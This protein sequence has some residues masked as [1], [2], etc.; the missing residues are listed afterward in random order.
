MIRCNKCGERSCGCSP[1]K[2]P[3]K[4]RSN[5]TIVINTNEIPNA[6]EVEFDNSETGLSSSNIQEAIEELDSNIEE[7]LSNSVKTIG[8]TLVTNIQDEED[9]SIL[10]TN[11]NGRI[12]QEGDRI[13]GGLRLGRS[14]DVGTQLWQESKVTIAANVFDGVINEENGSSITVQNSNI[15]QAIKT[16]G[17]TSNIVNS[18]PAK[19]THEIVLPSDLGSNKASLGTDGFHVELST[20]DYDTQ[21]HIDENI[22]VNKLPRVADDIEPTEDNELVTKSYVDN[23]P[24]DGSNLS[25]LPWAKAESSVLSYNGTVL[26]RSP[27]SE[28]VVSDA[29][30]VRTTRGELLAMAP[31]ISELETTPNSNTLVPWRRLKERL[32]GF[33]SNI[34]YDSDEHILTFERYDETPITVDLPIESLI[35]N[36]DLDDDDTL[37]LTFEDGS[38]REIPLSTLLVGVVKSVNNETPNSAG[39]VQLGINNIPDLVEALEGKVEKAEVTIDI[40]DVPSGTTVNTTVEGLILTSTGEPITLSFPQ[41]NIP[42][43]IEVEGAFVIGGKAIIETTQSGTTQ[44]L[45]VEVT[46]ELNSVGGLSSDNIGNNLTIDDLGKLNVGVPYVLEL[47][48]ALAGSGATIGD[49]KLMVVNTGPL[50]NE[51]IT[52][53]FD[54]EALDGI[55]LTASY[56]C[57]VLGGFID[58]QVG[59][60]TQRVNI[61]FTSLPVP[62]IPSSIILDNFSKII[63]LQTSRMAKIYT[64]GDQRQSITVGNFDNEDNPINRIQLTQF[65][66]PRIELLTNN[67]SIEFSADG[68]RKALHISPTGGFFTNSQSLYIEGIS[69]TTNTNEHTD[70]TVQSL[71]NIAIRQVANPS[72]FSSILHEGGNEYSITAVNN[73]DE[74]KGLQMIKDEDTEEITTRLTGDDIKLES[75]GIDLDL[76]TVGEISGRTLYSALLYDKEGF[77]EIGIT[78]LNGEENENSNL[79]SISLTVATDEGHNSSSNY[80]NY[81]INL[82]NKTDA[83]LD[84]NEGIHIGNVNLIPSLKKGFF[85]TEIG[86]LT[87]NLQLKAEEIEFSTYPNILEG[88]IL[89]DDN[90]LVP[91][92]YVD[93]QIEDMQTIINDLTQRLEA[94]ENA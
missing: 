57:V 27:V 47:D 72:S 90:Q 84:V 48:P 65:P 32:N 30:P 5:R 86:A 82:N 35:S 83:S 14:S 54:L 53:T 33:V 19:T 26:R 70:V 6:E 23:K 10:M 17:S 50:E 56:P 31:E 77:A 88:A 45:E 80:Y 37:I 67:G 81:A 39:N 16:Q 74:E 40:T 87:Y 13:T 62:N 76:I 59:A 66:T 63:T 68:V 41:D 43:K 21:L 25:N 73:E 24:I 61:D 22:T 94:L 15:T 38:T 34:S 52:L 75:K 20:P 4:N 9:W 28:S 69:I 12:P 29:V 55:V 89:A 8:N 11:T 85:F 93:Q 7:S 49:H 46:G 71:G 42:S 64:K 51:T 58:L 44:T 3:H 91:K 2:R 1:K 60:N 18:S 36:I 92:S 78:S 79:S